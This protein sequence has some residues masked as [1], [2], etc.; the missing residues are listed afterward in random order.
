MLMKGVI[1]KLL[2]VLLLVSFCFGLASSALSLEVSKAKQAPSI[3]T[4]RGD[5]PPYL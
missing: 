1:M 3:E 2:N 4:D 5:E